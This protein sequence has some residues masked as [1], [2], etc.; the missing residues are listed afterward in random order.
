MSKEVQFDFEKE[1]RPEYNRSDSKL[2]RL[3]VKLS[4]GRVDEAQA[5]YILL[6]VAMLAIVASFLLVFRGDS[7]IPLPPTPGPDYYAIP[8]QK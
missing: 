4:G 7:K 3:I 6:M 1:D 2:S 5:N 8:L